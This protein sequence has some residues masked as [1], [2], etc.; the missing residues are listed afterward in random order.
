M[1]DIISEDNFEGHWSPIEGEGIEKN[2]LE[3]IGEGEGYWCW[4]EGGEDWEENDSYDWVQVDEHK[5]DFESP[6]AFGWFDSSGVG[7][8]E[9]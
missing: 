9:G 3:W 1:N 5:W 2:Q 8:K 6:Y 7:R 4:I